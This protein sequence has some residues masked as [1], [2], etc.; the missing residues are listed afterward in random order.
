MHAETVF[1]APPP[2]VTAPFNVSGPSGM[3]EHKVAPSAKRKQPAS[4]KS[5]SANSKPAKNESQ[6][7][8]TAG[9]GGSQSCRITPAAISTLLLLLMVL[10][11]VDVF[12]LPN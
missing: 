3:G 1:P 2:S 9:N 7:I 12:R 11:D 6:I 5:T 4:P 10:I 8:S